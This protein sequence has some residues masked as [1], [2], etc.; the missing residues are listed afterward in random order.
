[1]VFCVLVFRNDGF[2]FRFWLGGASFRKV[3]LWVGKGFLRICLRL[4]KK[5]MDFVFNYFVVC[6]VFIFF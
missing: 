1:M 4:F 6:R 5:L 2:G 3:L